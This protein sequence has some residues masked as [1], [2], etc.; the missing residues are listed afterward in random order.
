M[1]L[2]LTGI[3]KILISFNQ[4]MQPF[5]LSIVLYALVVRVVFVIVFTG[6][7]KNIKL[8]P[9]LQPQID[10][11][12]KRHK[13]H[14]DKFS[15]E[16][17]ALMVSKGYS[18]FGN[19]I[20]FF[21][22]GLFALG[23]GFVLMNAGKYL[24]QNGSPISLMLF[25]LPLDLSP[26]QIM[27]SGEYPRNFFLYAGV[28]FLTATGLHTMLDKFLQEHSL[29][30]VK[31]ADTLILILLLIGCASLPMGVSVFWISVKF[32]DVIHI[33]LMMKFYK[34]DLDRLEKVNKLR[35][36]IRKKR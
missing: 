15:Q 1:D 6:Y 21:I 18:M 14:P 13:N 10:K 23:L 19:I 32:L 24:A 36:P 27:F 17:S 33:L 5:A 22:H 2:I 8:G 7:F 28:L 20:H 25:Q 26:A 35:K 11:L 29:M 31:R 34:V 30:D 4:I 3:G 9:A 16:L 12:K